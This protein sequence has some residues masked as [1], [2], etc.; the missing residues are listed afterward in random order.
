MDIEVDQR[1]HDAQEKIIDFPQNEARPLA[2]EKVVWKPTA[3][4]TPAKTRWS[5]AFWF[6]I[7]LTVGIALAVIAAGVA[8][9]IA[10][11]RQSRLKS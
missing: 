5:S 8:G 11:H 1:W 4:I 10:M 7:A 2:T 3:S 6:S 9:S